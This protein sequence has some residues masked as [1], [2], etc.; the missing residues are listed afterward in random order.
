MNRFDNMKK[1]AELQ[2]D[3]PMLKA[4][5]GQFLIDA[6]STFLEENSGKVFSVS[7]VFAGIYGELNAADI[8]EIKNKILNELSRGHRTGRFHRVPEQIGFYTW[9]YDLVNNG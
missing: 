8:R 3:I 5:D 4:Y 7:E 6:L 9:D 2:Q 1:R